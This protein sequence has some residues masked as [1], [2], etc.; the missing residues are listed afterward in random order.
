METM[1]LDKKTYWSMDSGNGACNGCGEKT[2][3][4]LFTATVTTLMQGRV[5]KHMERLTELIDRLEQHIRL[6]L[7]DTMDLAD[8]AAIRKAVD[9]HKDIDLTFSKLTGALDRGKFGTP[10]DTDWLKWVT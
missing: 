7:A 10:L 8:V 1:L 5:K 9:E 4:H 6:K 3:L 2:S